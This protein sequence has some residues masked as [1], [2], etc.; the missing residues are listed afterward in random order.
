[1]ALDHALRTVAEVPA[2]EYA[3]LAGF[4]VT[5]F[6]AAFVFEAASWRPPSL[7]PSSSYAASRRPASPRGSP[8]PRPSD[9]SSAPPPLPC[10]TH[11]PLQQG[12]E[13]GVDL[14]EQLLN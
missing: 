14:E 4:L 12:P 11:R 6:G 10:P 2:D 1:M 9:A 8:G 13:D 3:F 5:N 7:P